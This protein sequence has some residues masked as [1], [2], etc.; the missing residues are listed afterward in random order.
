MGDITL[1]QAVEEYKD[2]YMASRNFAQ[3]TRVEYLHDIEDL[4]NFLEQQGIR[5]VKNLGLPQL[6]RYL[7]EIDRRGFAGSTRKRKVVSIRSFLW[8]LYQDGY[9][10]ANLSKRLI[11]PFSDAINPRYLTKPE[12]ERL[13]NIASKNPRDFAIIQL[14]LQT[15]I[16]LSELTQL[17]IQDVELPTN[18]FP[19]NENVGY[20][21]VAGGKSKKARVIPLNFKVCIALRNYFSQNKMSLG[22]GLFINKDEENLSA[23]GIE[24][25]VRKYM[26]QINLTN[27]SVQSLRHTFGVHHIIAGSTPKM[28]KEVMGYRDSRSVSIYN[29][30]VKNGIKKQIQE[31]AL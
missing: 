23:R 9:I 19:E 27:A 12:Y 30:I 5:D 26:L 29:T 17:T 31:H 10:S 6:E 28:V 25:I 4:V 16:K 8:Y 18:I 20:L 2:I 15:G 7:A 1:R 13:L 24:K 11:P 22:Q 3:K 21:H 14:L